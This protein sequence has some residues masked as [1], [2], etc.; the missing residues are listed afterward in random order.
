MVL[1]AKGVVVGELV[2]ALNAQ[3]TTVKGGVLGIVVVKMQKRRQDRSSIRAKE[4][5]N[6]NALMSTNLCLSPG[7]GHLRSPLNLSY[8]SPDFESLSLMSGAP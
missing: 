4:F 5:P 3:A 8:G 7:L 2:V 1:K 6:W